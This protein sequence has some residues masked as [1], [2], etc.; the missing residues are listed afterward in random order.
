[1]LRNVLIISDAGL[2]LFSKEFISAVGQPRLVGSLLTAMLEFSTNNVGAPVCYI[3]MSN[4]AVSICSSRPPESPGFFAPFGSA[5]VGSA[6]HGSSTGGQLGASH[7]SQPNTST[8]H[9]SLPHASGVSP[10]K[11]P[12]ATRHKSDSL[13]NKSESHPS[14]TSTTPQV[15]QPPPSPS[16]L[17]SHAPP[18]RRKTTATSVRADSAS[19]RSH[20]KLPEALHPCALHSHRKL[21][22]PPASHHALALAPGG[23]RR[24]SRRRGAARAASRSSARSSTISRTGQVAAPFGFPFGFR[25]LGFKV[26]FRVWG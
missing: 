14:S 16:S 17:P 21:L 12:P 6:Q 20:P 25:V 13:H 15:P 1:M 7:G 9:G 23:R 4:V 3:E 11:P 18:F 2:V 22:Q 10:E 8:S 5:S 26:W 19:R 24:Q